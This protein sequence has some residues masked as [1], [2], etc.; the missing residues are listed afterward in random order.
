MNTKKQARKKTILYI[1]LDGFRYDYLTYEESPQLWEWSQQGTYVEKLVSTSGFVKRSAM[2]TGAHPNITLDFAMYEFCEEES[3]FKFVKPFAIP[4]TILT[5]LSS[6]S[7]KIGQINTRLRKTIE[8][9]TKYS[10]QSVNSIHIPLNLLPFMTCASSERPP[11]EKN[12]LSVESIFDLLCDDFCFEYLYYPVVRGDD[13]MVLNTALERAGNYSDLYIL[14]FSLTDAIGHKYGPESP[15]RRQ[16]VREVDHKLRILR[17]HFE[18]LFEEVVWFIVSDHGMTQ[19]V[20]KIN[21]GEIL[22]SAARALGLSLGRDYL[23]FLDSTFL[24][25][26]FLNDKARRLIPTIIQNNP[27]FQR[28]GM[29]LDTDLANQ[30]HIPIPSARYGDLAWWANPGVLIE[31]DFFNP[32]INSVKGM[33]GYDSYHADSLAMAVVTGPQIPKKL[34]EQAHLVDICPTLCDLLSIQYPAMNQG[35]SWLS[36]Q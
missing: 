9:R 12:V 3:P 14:Q 35:R 30:H 23:Y 29:L 10:G 8:K 1:S 17:D 21:A 22:V 6:Y 20:E 33:H 26:L 25:V 34:I 15:E 16:A 5:Q 27:L 32:G 18:Q 13:Q 31:P 7:Y 19:V 2:F 36:F 4:L 28:N 11:Y 24:R